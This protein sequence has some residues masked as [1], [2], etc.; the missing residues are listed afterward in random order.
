[1]KFH[2]YKI[3]QIG[4]FLEK[5]SRLEVSRGWVEGEMGSCCLIIMK[6]LSRGDEKILK[7]NSSDGFITLWM[8]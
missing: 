2:L 3:P 4:T 1:M 5:E 6:F 7:I 8:Y